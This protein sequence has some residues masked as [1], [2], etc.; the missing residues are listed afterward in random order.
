MEYLDAHCHLVACP[1]KR[2]SESSTTST[3]SKVKEEKPEGQKIALL[4]DNAR[5]IVVG[6]CPRDWTEVSQLSKLSKKF[7]NKRFVFI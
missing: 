1:L 5:E 3:A 4:P 6:T 2:L 7:P